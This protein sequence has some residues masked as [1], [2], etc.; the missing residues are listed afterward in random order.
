MI[1]E[2]NWEIGDYLDLVPVLWYDNIC[3]VSMAKKNNQDGEKIKERKSIYDFVMI[4]ICAE[5]SQKQMVEVTNR[6]DE[7]E[8]QK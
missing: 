4:Q 2:L 6:V 5:H 8:L 3:S 1:N 7:K